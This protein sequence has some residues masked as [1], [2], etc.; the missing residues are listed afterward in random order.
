MPSGAGAGH[1]DGPTERLRLAGHFRDGSAQLTWRHAGHV[2]AI[3]DFTN[4]ID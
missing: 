3:W 1:H 4:E 2:P